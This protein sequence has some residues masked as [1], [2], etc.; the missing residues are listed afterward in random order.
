MFAQSAASLFIPS[1]HNVEP[2]KLPLTGG[3]RVWGALALVVC[4]FA[5]KAQQHTTTTHHTRSSVVVPLRS[6]V[7]VHHAIA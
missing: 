7:M 5:E 6:C 1:G 4:Y 2:L 3:A